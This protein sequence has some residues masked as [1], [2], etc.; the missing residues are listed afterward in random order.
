MAAPVATAN[1]ADRYGEREEA[2]VAGAMAVVTAPVR[3]VWR[4]TGWQR[5]WRRRVLREV[6]SEARAWRRDV[7]V[8][9]LDQAAATQFRH[10][11]VRIAATPHRV[12]TA[13]LL[14]AAPPFALG[15]VA[16]FAASR[17]ARASYDAGSNPGQEA[18]TILLALAALSAAAFLPDH[19]ATRLGLREPG[20]GRCAATALAL[21][22]A[23]TAWFRSPVADWAPAS[24]ADGV[25]Y[26]A[27]LG[28]VGL[29]VLTIAAISMYTAMRLTVRSR[30]AAVAESVVIGELGSALTALAADGAWADGAKRAA[31]ADHLHRAARVVE[32]GLPERL[33]SADAATTSA[34]RDRCRRMAA[35]ID[36]LQRC[37]LLPGEGTPDAVRA[38]VTT[39]ARAIAAGRLDELPTADPPP[40]RSRREVVVTVLR[41]AIVAALP[42]A[43]FGVLQA[44]TA[45]VDGAVSGYVT[46]VCL[47]WAVVTVVSVL[48]P[49]FRDK[50]AAVRE[51]AGLLRP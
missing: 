22:V 9:D 13:M 35:A 30:D 1:A 21:V 39:A 5:R 33:R 43:V 32:H 38:S 27:T 50:V 3:M 28:F 31:A 12:L 19:V 42:A 18:V 45:A 11:A 23:A 48:D 25:A 36:E 10:D 47:A 49:L 44:S 2:D 29:C 40:G 16:L 8:L 6:L 7:Q 15:V 14:A 51:A 34:V 4:L 17:W 46:G 41:T 20:P 24:V 37:V 26:V